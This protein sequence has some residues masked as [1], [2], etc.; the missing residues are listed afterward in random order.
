VC[1]Y[2]TSFAR[3]YAAVGESARAGPADWH[4]RKSLVP[5]PVKLGCPTDGAVLH[6]ATTVLP[7]SC[8]RFSA[9][10]SLGDRGRVEYRIKVLG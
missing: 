1:R 8:T 3:A 6:A 10:G 4:A 5:Y 9:V 2:A 7:A